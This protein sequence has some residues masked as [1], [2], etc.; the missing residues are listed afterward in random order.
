MFFKSERG[1]SMV[2]MLGVLAVVG[3]LSIG[4]IIGYR[5]AVDK[6]KAGETIEELNRRVL[7]YSIQA[8]KGNETFFADEF[9]TQTK[10]GYPVSKHLLDETFFDIVLSQVPQGVCKQI[11]KS[12]WQTPAAVYVNNTLADSSSVCNQDKNTL[13]F[14]FDASLEGTQEAP[15]HCTQNSDCT[16]GCDICVEGVCKENC[17]ASQSCVRDINVGGA[18]LCCAKDK[19]LDGVCCSTIGV[20]SDG[21]KICCNS[22][23]KCCPINSFKPRSTDTE[24]KSCDDPE[25]YYMIQSSAIDVNGCLGAC[26]NRVMSGQYCALKCSV[27]SGSYDDGTRKCA[28]PADKLTDRK[29]NCYTCDEAYASESQL[30]WGD[31]NGGS[32]GG[33]T[34]CFKCNYSMATGYCYRCPMGTVSQM[35]KYD[36]SCDPCPADVSK[37][38]E[39]QCF[40][41]SG[42]FKNGKCFK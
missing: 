28:C 23:N 8:E 40:S 39:K 32:N 24:C 34:K 21:Q 5:Y 35:N 1:R 42:T 16:S 3:V 25:S 37:L 10:M 19:I 41:C 26:P 33:L 2:E 18:E 13:A 20:D 14:E 27:E 30:L 29:G 36:K 11:V 31:G 17:K 4:S 12:D 38:T 15:P 7:V 6:Y 9:D 22:S